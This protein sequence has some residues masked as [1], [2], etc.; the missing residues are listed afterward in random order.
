MFLSRGCFSAEADFLISWRNDAR[1]TQVTKVHL[2]LHSSSILDLIMNQII[3]KLKLCF[4]LAG[5]RR[6]NEQRRKTLGI[7]NKNGRNKWQK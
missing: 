7:F 6:K 2:I 1:L 3:S 4:R 5:C